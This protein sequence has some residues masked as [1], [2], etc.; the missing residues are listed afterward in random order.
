MCA[1]AISIEHIACVWQ[2][3]HAK[4]RGSL[5]TRMDD[6]RRGGAWAVNFEQQQG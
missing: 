6:K 3:L 5:H 1:G 2:G 4:I